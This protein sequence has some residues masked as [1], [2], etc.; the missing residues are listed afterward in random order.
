MTR[1]LKFRELKPLE[2]WEYRKA[3][4]NGR[5]LINR[6][7]VEGKIGATVSHTMLLAGDLYDES[8]CEV[9][10]VTLRDGRC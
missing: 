1:Y 10:T 7:P 6:R 9:G 4:R 3:R 8:N 5:L 2:A